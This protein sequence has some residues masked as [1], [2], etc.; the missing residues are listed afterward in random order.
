MASLTLWSPGASGL[1]VGA[2]NHKINYLTQV[3][4]IL[5]LKGNLYRMIGS[6]V[7]ATVDIACWWSCIGKGLRLQP[8]QQACFYFFTPN[9][10]ESM[11]GVSMATYILPRPKI[12]LQWLILSHPNRAVPSMLKPN[13]YMATSI[14]EQG[15]FMILTQ[16]MGHFMKDVLSNRILCILK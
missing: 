4:E 7:T 15:S 8:A 5:T 1:R 2:S 14:R 10:G 6:M 11:S 12:D 9:K 3:W 16:K 13:F